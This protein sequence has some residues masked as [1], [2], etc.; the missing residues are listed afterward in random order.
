MNF[1]VIRRS[2]IFIFGVGRILSGKDASEIKSYCK[3]DDG[4]WLRDFG[5]PHQTV[6]EK[7]QRRGRQCRRPRME[8]GRSRGRIRLRPQFLPSPDMRRSDSTLRRDGLLLTQ[9]SPAKLE[10]V[11]LKFALEEELGVTFLLKARSV[12]TQGGSGRPH[13]GVLTQVTKKASSPR[14]LGPGR[15]APSQ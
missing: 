9:L 1:T 7:L 11:L 3:G 5:L 6:V 15:I 8:M 14:K 12:E 2:H 13:H 10:P 4:G